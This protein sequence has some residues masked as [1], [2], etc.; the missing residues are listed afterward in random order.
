MTN[1]EKRILLN[2]REIM[3]ML[4]QVIILDKPYVRPEYLKLANGLGKACVLTNQVLESED[5]N[6]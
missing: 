2:Q 3:N 1:A 4:N 6:D 5:G